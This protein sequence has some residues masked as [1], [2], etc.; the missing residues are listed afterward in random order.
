MHIEIDDRL[1]FKFSRYI[2]FYWTL[3]FSL[4]RII[5]FLKWKHNFCDFAD[6]R[7]LDY[8]ISLRSIGTI[9][10]W[11]VVLFQRKYDPSALGLGL[12]WITML[13]ILTYMRDK[14]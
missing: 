3:A 13:C 14:C 9:Y 2:L 4:L 5:R 11:P 12:Q 6:K 8:I 10:R 1:F 7:A